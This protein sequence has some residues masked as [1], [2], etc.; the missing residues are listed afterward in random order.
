MSTPNVD[1]VSRSIVLHPWRLGAALLIVLV[2]L[3]RIAVQLADVQLLDRKEYAKRASAEINQVISLT[4]SRGEIHD[5]NGNILALDVDRESLY[6]APVQVAPEDAARLAV[7]L[8]AILDMP[9]EKILA[10]LLDTSRAWVPIK[11][12]L[13]PEVAAKIAILDEASLHLVYEPHRFYPQGKFAPHI[14][15]ATNL[16]GLGIAGVEASFDT[17]LRGT[18]G[19]ITAEVDINRNPIW[20]RPYDQKLPV[21]GNQLTL[22]IDSYIQ[23]VAE[24]ELGQAIDRHGASGG[25]AIV[26]DVK[27]GAVLAMASYPAFDPNDYAD[28]DPS[29]YNINPAVGEVYEPGST[30]K[31]VTVAAGLQAKAFDESTQVEDNGTIRRYDYNLANFDYKGHGVMTPA[32]VLYY[33]SNIGALLFAEMTGESMFYHTVDAFG[34][35]KLTGIELPGETAGIY[36]KPGTAGY[37]PINLNTNSFGQ[38]IA[39]TPLQIAR[40]AATIANNGVMMRPYIIKS[41]CTKEAC[42]ETEPREQG[43]PI[44]AD[45][46]YRVRQ[47]VM[48]S[49]NHYVNA[50]EPDTNWLVPGFQVGAKTGTSSI[51]DGNGG[52]TNQTI[53]SVVGMAPIESPR[54]AVLVKIDRPQDDIWGVRTA[55]PV[56]RRIVAEL[57]R[58]DRVAPDNSLVGENQQPGVINGG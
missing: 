34:F 25:T 35:G 30:F 26:L 18:D 56:Y 29:V 11:R 16:N 43:R 57:M 1:N 47:M 22:T 20:A 14:I 40:M 44:D 49:A 3:V 2:A 48:K 24:A 52:Y 55:L 54:Y 31:M 51:P 21:N 46:A 19:V 4:A 39:V 13:A 23:H 7:T 37:T 53:G 5:R 10:K 42:V 33:S 17:F 45:V 15:G 38:G 28:V 8:G 36:W 41:R 32:G 6:V 9:A 27:T 12:W 50:T 58:Y